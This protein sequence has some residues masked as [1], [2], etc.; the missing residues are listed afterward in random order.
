MLVIG[1]EVVGVPEAKGGG[2]GRER[3]ATGEGA[4]GRVAGEEKWGAAEGG[5]ARPI[6]RFWRASAVEEGLGLRLGLKG[7]RGRRGTEEKG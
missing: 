2:P 7:D 4:L 3:A 6:W 1:A 5:G